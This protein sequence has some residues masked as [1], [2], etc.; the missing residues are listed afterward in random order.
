MNATLQRIRALQGVLAQEGKQDKTQHTIR[1]LLVFLEPIEFALAGLLLSTPFLQPV[2]LLGLSTPLGGLLALLGLLQVLGKGQAA[3]PRRLLDR[4]IETETI[5]KILYYC[6][7]LLLS[8]EKVPHWELGRGARIL[9]HPRALGWHIVFM[10][11]VLALPLPIPF[12]NSVPAWGIVFSCLAM[13]EFNGIFVALSYVLLIANVT[14]FGALV[15]VAV[16][17]LMSDG[18]KHLFSHEGYQ[19]LMEMLKSLF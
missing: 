13:I 15:Y 4:P 1:E 7:K 9:A 19:H 18:V 6:E 10:S 3:L 11:V 17:I 8:L 5:Q 16:K 12:S 2:P 14:F